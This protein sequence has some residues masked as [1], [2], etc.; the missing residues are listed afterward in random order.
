MDPALL[1]LAVATVL[2]LGIAAAAALKGWRGWL[3]LKQLELMNRPAG[4]PSSL[5]RVEIFELK[6]RIRRLEAIANGSE[7]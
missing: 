5:S 1:A 3:E 2:G 4:A 7:Q 6:E